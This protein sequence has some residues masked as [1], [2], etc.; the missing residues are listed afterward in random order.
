VAR[1]RQIGKILD[2]GGVEGL[3][4]RRCGERAIGNPILRAID[5]EEPDINQRCYVAIVSLRELRSLDRD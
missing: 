4:C 1:D 3:N 5:L 2:F